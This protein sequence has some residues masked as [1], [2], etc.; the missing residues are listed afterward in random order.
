MKKTPADQ[1]GTYM[2]PQESEVVASP[3]QRKVFEPLLDSEEAAALLKIHPK[4]L[5]KMAR[6]GEI[7]GIQ[8]GRL[9]RFR[10]SALNQWLDKIAS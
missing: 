10:A 3:I 8:V 9:W 7:T 1:N 4:T 6:E 5:Q 2:R